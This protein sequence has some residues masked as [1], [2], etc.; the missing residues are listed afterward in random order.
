MMRMVLR[1]WIVLLA[2]TGGE[3]GAS[4]FRHKWDTEADLMG[5]HGQGGSAVPSSIDFAATTTA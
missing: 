4:V 1:A 3:A 5:M 2:T